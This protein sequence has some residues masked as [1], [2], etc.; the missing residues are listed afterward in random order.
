M[1]IVRNTEPG[2]AGSDVHALRKTFA[3]GRQAEA[4]PS[5]CRGGITYDLLK[6]QEG[7]PAGQQ[8]LRLLRCGVA[9]IG[10]SQC[11]SQAT[12]PGAERSLHG[13][14][15]GAAAKSARSTCST[16]GWA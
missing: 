15:H 11:R 14:A 10:A 2:I 4:S 1:P 16:E 13:I 9:L 5:C 8:I 3:P 6:L 12:C 7:T